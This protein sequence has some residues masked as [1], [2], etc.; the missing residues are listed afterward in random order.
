M[1]V[2]RI[3]FGPLYADRDPSK[4]EPWYSQ[5]V[6]AMTAE[7]LHSK[8]DIAAELAHRD[9]QIRELMERI[10]AL[11]QQ[12]EALASRLGAVE[13]E[14]RHSVSVMSIVRSWLMENVRGSTHWENCEREHATCR[15]ISQLG[16]VVERLSRLNLTAGV[17]ERTVTNEET[18]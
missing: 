13:D 1:K 8:S 14:L 5:H 15:A 17:V 10:V 3:K 7:G 6:N 2:G 11:E 4:L 16:G 9:R 12:N 18:Q